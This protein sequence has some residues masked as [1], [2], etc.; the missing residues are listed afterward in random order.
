MKH[1]F[2]NIIGSYKH[3]PYTWKHY[4]AFLKVEKKLLGEYRY[5]FHDWDKLFMYVFLPWLGV[6][7][8]SKIHQKYNSHHPS[9]S[10][11]YGIDQLKKAYNIDFVEAIIDWECARYTKKDKSLNAYDTLFAYYPE[12]QHFVLPMLAELKLIE[13]KQMA[14]SVEYLRGMVEDCISEIP[15]EIERIK[16]SDFKEN[17]KE[18]QIA[19]KEGMRCAY[20]IIQKCL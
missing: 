17:I 10:D 8:I 7:R 1:L 9:W 2:N 16:N 12:Y 18:E 15:S 20:Q 5:K 4:L 3:I 13:R 6:E 14:V 19:W 11:K